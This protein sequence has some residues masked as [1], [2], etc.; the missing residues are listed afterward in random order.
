MIRAK[1]MK[2][3]ATKCC[4]ASKINDPLLDIAKQLEE[5]ALNDPYFIEKHLYP[6]VDFYSGILLRGHEHPHQHVSGDVCHRPSAGLDCPV[7]RTY[8]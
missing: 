7:E 4:P 1:I 5:V 8:G 2:K 6:N 3:S